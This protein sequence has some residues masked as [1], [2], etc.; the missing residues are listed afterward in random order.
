MKLLLL[1]LVLSSLVLV[2]L[3]V[4]ELLV[5]ARLV[6]RIVV[7]EH[8]VVGYC[9]LVGKLV[10]L[11]VEQ[12]EHIVV[13]VELEQLDCLQLDMVDLQQQ[14]M[15]HP[16]QALLSIPMASDSL[17]LMLVC[18]L[19]E[20]LELELLGLVLLGL[21]LLVVLLQQLVDRLVV[22]LSEP[23]GRLAGRLVDKSVV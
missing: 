11:L 7:L 22:E 13:L 21:G 23:V 16:N 17:L 1:V 2:V 15:D 10:V 5:V 20:L 8:I 14:H 3:A 12:L 4:V 19:A 6:V 18:Q 9:K